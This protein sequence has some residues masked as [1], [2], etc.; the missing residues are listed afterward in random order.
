V[1]RVALRHLAD[2]AAA[3]DLGDVIQQDDSH[4]SPSYSV[5]RYGSRA[6]VRARLIAWVS[7]RWWRA[8]LPEMRRGMILPRSLTKVLSRRPSLPSH[9]RV[10]SR[11]SIRI[12]L[13]LSRYSP[14]LSACLPQATTVRNEVS[15]RLSPP[16][17]V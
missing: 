7:W 15:S 1:A 16:C 3:P 4:R 12:G 2:L 5:A 6:T 11:P 9:S 14:Q 17:V 13:P 10:W 8:Q